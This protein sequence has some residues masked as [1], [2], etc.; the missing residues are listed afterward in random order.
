MRL[1][2]ATLIVCTAD[3]K[4]QRTWL[5]P[6]RNEAD[7]MNARIRLVL[8]LAPQEHVPDPD[9]W[10]ALYNSQENSEDIADYSLADV[11]GVDIHVPVQ[12][13]H[14][15]CPYYEEERQR[16]AYTSDVFDTSSDFDNDINSSANS[17]KGVPDNGHNNEIIQKEAA[18]FSSTSSLENGGSEDLHTEAK[19]T[20]AVNCFYSEDIVSSANHSGA[21]VLAIAGSRIANNTELLLANLCLPPYKI[22]PDQCSWMSSWLRWCPTSTEML[23]EAEKRILSHA[24]SLTISHLVLADPWG[25]PERPLDVDELYK[26]PLWAK[27]LASVAQHFNPLSV[28]R[29]T[30]PLGPSLLQKARPDLTRKFA[31]LLPNAEEDIPSYLYHCNAQQPSGETAFHSLMS[32]FGWAK[33]PMVHRLDSLQQ[34]V[35]ITLIYGSRSWID[36]DPGFHIKYSRP[37]SF[38]DVQVLQGAGHHVII[39]L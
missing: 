38:V 8:A 34:E 20:I 17:E 13:S 9:A 12:S 35:P 4:P 25:F 1:A 10:Q 33:H 21:E 27:A 36:R 19:K 29:F 14:P 11:R 15:Q 22:L 2:L 28:L 16:D 7:S 39:F 26:L 6:R 5:F 37:N 3:S 32:G 23:R 30:G 18:P 24:H 31:G